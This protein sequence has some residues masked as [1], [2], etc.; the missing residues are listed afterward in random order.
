MDR[1]G[2]RRKGE[3]VNLSKSAYT[4]VGKDGRV[5]CE[6]GLPAMVVSRRAPRPDRKVMQ[7]DDGS[8]SIDVKATCK[9][10]SEAKPEWLLKALQ[11]ASK[12]RIQG[13]EVFNIVTNPKFASGVLEQHGQ[14]MLRMLQEHLTFFSERQHRTLLVKCELAQKFRGPSRS[15]SRSRKRGRDREA[16]KPRRARRSRSRSDK[17]RRKDSEAHEDKNERSSAKTKRDVSADR[18]SLREPSADSSASPAPATSSKDRA[19]AE[20]KEEEDK[21]RAA[22]ERERLAKALREQEQQRQQDIARQQAEKKAQQ[23]REAARKAKLGNAFAF[24]PEDDEEVQTPGPSA[25][26]LMKNRDEKKTGFT[27]GE[28][29]SSFGGPLAGTEVT[30]SA[31]KDKKVPTVNPQFVETMG[32]EQMLKDVHALLMQRIAP[33][34]RSLTAQARGEAKKRD[35]SRSRS[36]KKSRS[37]ERR[38]ERRPERG[39]DTERRR[40]GGPRSPTPDGRARGQARAARKAKMIAMCLGNPANSR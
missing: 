29:G 15:R 14:K 8:I 36:R 5:V 30:M 19:D 34:N 3:D 13:Q 7:D 35:R 10:T 2:R 4:T 39:R 24:D 25:L 20:H 40:G 37:R 28:A 18:P 16:E 33:E 38:P 11:A 22:E 31:G 1:D 21:K 12:G 9:L 32:G 26:T 23:E 27:G 17:E 6:P